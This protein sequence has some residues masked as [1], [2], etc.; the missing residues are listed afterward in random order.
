MGLEMK[1]NNA[2]NLP[3]YFPINPSPDET[4]VLKSYHRV[5]SKIE[6]YIRGYYLK[7]KQFLI[8]RSTVNVAIAIMFCSGSE[9]L[10]LYAKHHNMVIF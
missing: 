5:G 4:E 9:K 1:N 7:L 3:I 8:N 10:L 2:R 6:L